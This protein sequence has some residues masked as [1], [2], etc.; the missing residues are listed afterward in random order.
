MRNIPWS[1]IN[2]PI[3][4]RRRKSTYCRRARAQE[5][6]ATR[7]FFEPE[8]QD[9]YSENTIIIKGNLLPHENSNQTLRINECP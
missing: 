4:N 3:L 9:N 8:A 5:N 1:G 6:I 2:I 7:Q